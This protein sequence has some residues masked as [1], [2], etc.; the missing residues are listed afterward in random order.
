MS[1]PLVVIGNGMAAARFCEELSS[2]A[3]GRYAV[4]VI[5]AEPR[6]AYNRVLLSSVLA[7]EVPS[8]DIELKPQG[9]WRDRGITLR[10]G[11]RATEI[12][13]KTRTVTLADGARLE[14][15]KLVFAT[16]SQPIRPMIPGMALPGVITFRDIND[17][18]TIWHRAGAGDRVV[19]IG[20]GLLG[21]EA[22]YGLAKAGARV[23]VL[24]L[25]D[26]LMERQLDVHAAAMLQRALEAI[27]IE[28]ILKAD[29]AEISGSEG[30]EGVTL[31][32]GRTIEAN[33]VVVAIGIT[34]SVGL[35]R[36]AG[37]AVNRG[38]LVDDGLETNAAAIHAIGECAEHRGICYGLV[39][40]AHEQARVLADRLSGRDAHYPGSVLATN[41]KV[42]GVNVFS[43]GDFL[44]HE[45]AE[46]IILSDSGVGLYKKFIIADGR[47]IGSV[48]FGDTADGLWYLDLI[49]SGANIEH[50]RDDLAFGRALAGGEVPTRMA[51]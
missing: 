1:E 43:A 3:L 27:G 32:D 24:H 48:L 2:R 39:E 5:G 13:T 12:E 38:I 47:L 29:T 40:P 21:L 44:G 14:F 26:R 42:S 30:V 4:A 45:G 6:L 25:M 17:I 22:A 19:V 9:W 28:V 31:K 15:A 36:E 37:I 35:A 23:T 41:L 10:Y 51:A 33:A 20:G 16:G 50:I 46:E 49:R 34:A 11:C 8:S 7:G 18:W